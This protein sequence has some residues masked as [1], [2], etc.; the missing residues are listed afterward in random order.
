MVRVV[1]VDDHPVSRLGLRSMLASV[2]DIEVVDAVADRAELSCRDAGGV[3]VVICDP[4]P[5]GEAASL[6]SVRELS[7]WAPVLVV[8]SSR[9]AADAR[10]AMRA[11]ARGYVTKQASDEVYVAA[12]RSVAAGLVFVSE[13]VADPLQV[14]TSPSEPVVGAALSKRE[15]EA[16]CYIARGFTHQQAA[17]RMGV[18]KATVDTYVARIRA[19]L[20]L[21]NKAELALAALRFIEQPSQS[22]EQII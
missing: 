11:G 18:S 9:F 16:L 19:K 6:E 15:R 2:S 8:S 3:D 12:I 20:R 7:E 13:H 4:Y 14:G 5:F 1:I 21:G 10:A 17:R 22:V